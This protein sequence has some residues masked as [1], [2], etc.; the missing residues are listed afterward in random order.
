MLKEAPTVDVYQVLF[1]KAKVGWI[2]P[3]ENSDGKAI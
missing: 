3:S 2:I 1:G